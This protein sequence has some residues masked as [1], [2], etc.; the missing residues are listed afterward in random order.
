VTTTV[1]DKAVAN[2]RTVWRGI[3]QSVSTDRLTG[4][5][6]DLPDSDLRAIRRQVEECLEGRGGEVSAR[7]RA[8]ALG[9]TYLGLSE[10]G[11]RRFL[12]MLANE[13]GADHAEAKRVAQRILDAGDAVE[14][15]AAE[16]EMRRALTPPARLLLTQF[17]ALPQG[18]KFLVDMRA[19]LLGFK[20]DDAAL[21]E[22]DATLRDLLASWFDIGFLEMRR[23]TWEAPAAL[24]E[25]LIEYE[26]VHEIRSWDDLKH[27]LTSDRRCYAFFHPG[28]PE[29]PLI[30]VQVALVQG[31]AEN[32]Q[33][34][35]DEDQPALAPEEA[36]T[37]IFYSISN[38]QAGL[39]GISFGNFLIKRVV[40]DL[41]RD[42]PNLK[43]FSTLSPIPGLRRYV[44]RRIAAGD[45]S[46]LPA[47]AIEWLGDEGG[48]ERAVEHL[49]SRAWLNE[50]DR[51]ERLSAPLLALAARYLVREKRSG[52]TALDPVA[53]F[54][55]GNGARVERI[56]WLGDT[57]AN[58]MRQSAGMM[59]NYRYRLDQIERNHERYSATGEASVS[60]AV[61]GLLK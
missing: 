14:A 11:R 56:N 16:R 31:M 30:F 27:R 6:P 10:S 60:S 12:G 3:A 24:L 38:T 2:L 50:E 44:E 59:V 37:A 4:L 28:M 17:N 13:F 35:L 23:L 32:I 9:R 34:L 40:D 8:A 53:H 42:L 5:K 54:H 22:L 39:R 46:V 52:G 29:E 47:G 19:E 61:A 57:S 26:A 51:A 49:F 1:L 21:G 41:A 45:A 25:K 15:G 43:T 18:V 55:L 7:A 58:G 36:D 33:S 48:P 20:G